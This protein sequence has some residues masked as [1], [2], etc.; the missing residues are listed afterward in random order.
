MANRYQ[1][2][3]VRSGLT[4]RLPAR[5]KKRA[6]ASSQTAKI[7]LPFG[8]QRL[9]RPDYP[10]RRLTWII[11]AGQYARV[12]SEALGKDVPVVGSYALT[13][14]NPQ[15]LTNVLL[16]PIAG[17]YVPVTYTANAID[18]SFFVLVIGGFIGVVTAAG[19]I[20]AGIKHARNASRASCDYVES[21]DSHMCLVVI[22]PVQ[23]DHTMPAPLSLDI[24]LR[25]QRCIDD[26]LS[27]R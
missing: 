15:G 10:C 20:D 8:L 19:A 1:R 27:G 2:R 14:A 6:D 21:G 13:E 5:S 11:P 24:R 17:F 9:I 4:S 7:P 12:R 18:V 25:F 23:E 16:A 22:H 26:G 3:P